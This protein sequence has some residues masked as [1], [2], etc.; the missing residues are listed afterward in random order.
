MIVGIYLSCMLLAIAA[1]YLT[2]KIKDE[3][4]RVGM[5]FTALVLSFVTLIC[6]PWFLKILVIIPLFFVA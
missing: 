6:A 2:T 4:F 3:V 5:T 1:A